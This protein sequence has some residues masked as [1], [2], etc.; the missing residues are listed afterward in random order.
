M[1]A[2]T[3][4]TNQ[5]GGGGIKMRCENCYGTL[6]EML[7]PKDKKILELQADNERLREALEDECGGRCNAEYNPCNARL[8]LSSTP[9][10]SLAEHDNEII[11]HCADTALYWLDDDEDKNELIRNIVESINK[12]KVTP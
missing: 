12:L 5:C 1:D 10:Q 7:A 8:V 3:I 9:A 2:I 11:H 6:A 4:S